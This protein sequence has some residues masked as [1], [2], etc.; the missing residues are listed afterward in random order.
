MLRPGLHLPSGDSRFFVHATYLRSFCPSRDAGRLDPPDQGGDN[1]DVDDVLPG[2]SEA[3]SAM[4]R[5]DVEPAVALVDPDVDWRADRRGTGGGARPRAVTARTRRAG[6]SSSRSTRARRDRVS[7]S[8]RWSRLLR[9]A[10]AWWSAGAGRWRMGW[11]GRGA[12]RPGASGAR[13]ADCGLPGPP[14]PSRRDGLRPT[15]GLNAGITSAHRLLHERADPCLFG[16]GQ[17]LQR[18]GGRPHGAVVEV[19][20]VAEAERRVPA[21]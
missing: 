20:L 2:L 5:G 12:A 15:R 14:E 10:T 17:L 9:L 18:E 1:A 19:R 8:S 21:S 3:L 13:R 16:G 7:S 11:R 4:N 6:I